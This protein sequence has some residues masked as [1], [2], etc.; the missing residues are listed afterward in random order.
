MLNMSF[1]II[2]KLVGLI[3][4]AMP[5]ILKKTEETIIKIQIIVFNNDF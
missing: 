5:K 1:L 3:A 4:T 2:D